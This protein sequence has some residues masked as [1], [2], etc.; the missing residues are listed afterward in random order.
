MGTH[1]KSCPLKKRPIIYPQEPEKPDNEQTEA[2]ALVKLPFDCDQP[3]DLS[4][5]RKKKPYDN[6][7][8]YR[9]PAKRECIFSLRKPRPESTA[10]NLANSSVLLSPHND[11]SNSIEYHHSSGE[12]YTS[13]LTVHTKHYKSYQEAFASAAGCNPTSSLWQTYHPKLSEIFPSPDSSADSS[14]Q[15]CTPPASP[16]ITENSTPEDLSMHSN[17]PWL[18]LFHST[19][20][21]TFEE[22][23][24]SRSV[25]SRDSLLSTNSDS[26]CADK[27]FRFNCDKCNKMFSTSIGLTKHQQFHCPGSECQREKKQYCCQDCGKTYRTM[28]AL[29]MHISTHTKPH[30]CQKCGKAFSRSWLLKGHLRTH[31]GE[32]PFECSVCP[33]SFADRSNLRAHQQTHIENKKYAC[34]ICRKSFSRMSL[35]NKHSSSCLITV[36]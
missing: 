35:L 4:I 18:I 7:E 27:T 8:N 17:I 33:R 13:E 36:V 34:E 2:L 26:Y 28:G 20:T 30:K 10:I 29:K 14:Q 31:T 9:M 32:K 5:K 16:T 11:A 6:I 19:N 23:T 21:S 3:Q 15:Q 1:Y 12:I 22:H 24:P 25:S